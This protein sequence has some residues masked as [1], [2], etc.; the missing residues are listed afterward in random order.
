MTSSKQSRETE[1]LQNGVF[2]PSRA[3]IAREM[4][5]RLNLNDCA[6]EHD[7]RAHGKPIPTIELADCR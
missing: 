6:E 4:K 2:Q 3:E 1:R 7:S 5:C